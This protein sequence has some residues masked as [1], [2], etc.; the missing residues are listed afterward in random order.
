MMMMMHPGK[1]PLLVVGT[2][3]GDFRGLSTKFDV[4]GQGVAAL[5]AEARARGQKAKK[6]VKAA[7]G[8]ALK[9]LKQKM[10]LQLESNLLTE[11]PS[12]A[13]PISVASQNWAARDRKDGVLKSHL[14]KLRR[15]AAEI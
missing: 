13:D 1:A 4:L 9:H 8:G 6:T 14:L 2:T 10:G 3:G 11:G 15:R 7:V 5:M 12:T